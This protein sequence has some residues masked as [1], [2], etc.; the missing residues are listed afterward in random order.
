MASY[1][2]AEEGPL[3]GLIIRFEEGSEWILGRDPD[4]SYQVLEDPMV[5][6]KHVICRLTDDGYVLENLS[7]VNPASVNGKPI[8]EPVLLQEGDTV[9]IGNVFFHFTLKDPIESKSTEEEVEGRALDESSTIYEESD[10]LGALAFSG[11][12]DARWI[13]KVIS[14]PNAGAEFGLPEG[15]TYIIGKDPDTC[16]I[17][18]Q[19]LS[20]SRQHAKITAKSD[21]T[22]TIEDL[23]SLNKVLINGQEIGAPTQLQSQDLVALG[24]T[25]FLAIDQQQTR[26]TIISPSA[27][28]EYTPPHAEKKEEEANAAEEIAKKNWKKMIIPTRHLIIAGIFAILLILGLGG[29]FSLFKSEAITLTM[30]DETQ[31]VA[32]A[33]KNFPEVEFSFNP[34]TGKLFILG[35]VMT[36]IDQQEMIYQ[37]K[38]L[39]FVHSIDDNVIIDELVW[40]NTNALLMKN[41][42]WRAVNLTSI[43]PGHYV[44]RGYVQ[45]LDDSAKLSEYININFP[46]LDKLDNQVVVENTL[47]AQ[48]QGILMQNQ[49][50]NVTFQ[51]S[52]GELVLAGRVPSNQEKKYNEMISEFKKLKG[53]RMVKNFVVLSQ[54]TSDIVDISSKYKVTGSS[55]YGNI[56]QYVVI[57]GKILSVGSDLDGMTITQMQNNSIL[58]EKDG[59]KYRI[60]YNQP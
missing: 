15:S 6:R 28:L 55:K 25:S 7:A 49:F 38:S 47:E 60:N 32:K 29:V 13:I 43:I 20:V 57:N 50:G 30:G 23:G 27:G 18:F 35:H 3:A 33:L 17:L 14:G 16:D 54:P 24:T 34:A 10:D 1:L 36:E 52:N 46:Y 9:Q 56:N 2:V 31:E 39:S 51:F 53:V 41:P 37:L 40:E 21:G 58:L 59:I 11:A 19:D 5:S 4:V 8:D 26:E 42:A 45:N 12:S 48:I 44:L 22:V